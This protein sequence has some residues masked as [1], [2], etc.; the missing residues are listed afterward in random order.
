[1]SLAS[2]TARMFAS[3]RET[4]TTGVGSVSAPTITHNVL[5]AQ[6]ALTPVS[7]IST[8]ILAM[9]AGVGTI[10]LTALIG[11]N[12]KAIDATGLKVQWLHIRATTGNANPVT[13]AEGASNGYALAGAAW[14][15]VL[16]ADQ[17]FSFIG[18]DTTPDVG[19]TDKII[20]I[21]GTTTQSIVV[22]I[23]LG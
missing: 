8:F 22:E 14:K 19:P 7:E 12:G 4:F 21:T 3:V 17:Q 16:N 2:A 10:D 20:D 13:I 23:I 15:V 1:M 11:T 18:N 9:E 6:V 5:G